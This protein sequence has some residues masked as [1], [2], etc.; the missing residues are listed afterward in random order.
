VNI[1]LLAFRLW[2]LVLCPL[3]GFVLGVLAWLWVEELVVAGAVALLVPGAMVGAIGRV[4]RVSGARRVT[5][6][7]VASVIS[8]TLG[9]ALWLFFETYTVDFTL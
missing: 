5:Y 1:D 3:G 9:G 2:S 4:L 6:G 7:V 8:A